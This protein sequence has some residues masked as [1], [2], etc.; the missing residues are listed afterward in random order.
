MLP[1][2]VPFTFS[3]FTVSVVISKVIRLAAYVHTVPLASFLLF[4]PTFWIFDISA[5][6]ILRLLLWHQARGL[7]ASV[8]FCFGLVIT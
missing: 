4:F 8:A 6:C 3:L 7:L 1:P 5:I 2:V